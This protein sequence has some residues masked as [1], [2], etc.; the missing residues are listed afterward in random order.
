M[1]APKRLAE[2]KRDLETF[3]ILF[4]AGAAT[5]KFDR[6]GLNK[7]LKEIGRGARRIASIRLA[8]QAILV[9][10]KQK[11]FRQ[12]PGMLIED[13]TDGKGRCAMGR[14][15]LKSMDRLMLTRLPPRW[16]DPKRNSREEQN[17]LTGPQVPAPK[18]R[19]CLCPPRNE[20]SD[21]TG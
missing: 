10:H 7:Q 20:R 8:N 3:L 2:N 19:R 21:I 5:A 15:R 16:S 17:T 13:W 4:F 9:T 11:V 1:L 12:V 6:L 14:F 18:T